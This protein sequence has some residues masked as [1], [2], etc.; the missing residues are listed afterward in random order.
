MNKE[1]LSE[2]YNQIVPNKNAD[3]LETL[4]SVTLTTNEHFNLTAI[5]DEEKFRELMI[6]DSLLPLKYAEFDGKKV[7]DVGTGAGFPGLPLAIST[8]GEF[9]LLDSTAKKINHIN[10]FAKEHGINNVIGVSARAEDF[11]HKNVEKYDIAIARAVSAL[12][13]LLEL[14]LPMLK[15]GGLF[16][17]MKSTKSDEEIKLSQNALKVLGGEIVDIKKDILPESNEERNLIIIKKNKSCPNKYP[18]PY[19]QIKSKNL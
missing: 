5:K 14:C 8:K 2:L 18:R 10:N 7:I 11:A 6:Y 4:L 12:P 3:L 1:K 16:L 15:V 13:I 17:A 9:T 19:N